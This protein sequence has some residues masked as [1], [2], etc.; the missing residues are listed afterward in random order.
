MTTLKWLGH[1]TFM[2]K[3]NIVIYT[4]PFR[5]DEY[6][7][8][9]NNQELQTADLI[10]ISH[11]HHD[12]FSV[13]DIKIISNEKTIIVGPENI[14]EGLKVNNIPYAKF[15]S[16]L[17]DE[18]FE[19]EDVVVLAVP[20]Y[21]T[22]KAFH[23]KENEW[24]GYLL[25]INNKEYYF[26]GDTDIIPEMKDLEGVD[27][28]LLPVSGTFVMTSNEAADAVINI[29]KPLMAIPM[30][31]NSIVGSDEDANNF[32]SKVTKAGFMARKLNKGDFIEL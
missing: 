4:D 9:N 19:V 15:E 8:E 13:N 14:E 6:I 17:P 1:D 28:A 29:I 16:I 30:H 22:N 2:I 3:S 25:T 12:H 11:T 7:K 32:V 18:E 23:P 10:L 26:S 27:I 21:N 24:V 20:A 31:F 5:L